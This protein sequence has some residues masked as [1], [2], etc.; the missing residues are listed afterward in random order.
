MGGRAC[1][2]ARAHVFGGSCLWR[3]ARACLWGVVPVAWR[4]R[5]SWGGRACRLSRA[6]VERLLELPYQAPRPFVIVELLLQHLPKTA[7]CPVMTM[8]GTLR[9]HRHA[10]TL[11]NVTAILRRHS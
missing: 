2:V 11:N 8:L 10:C 3:G 6:H 7:P 1:G 4:A 9:K 5:M